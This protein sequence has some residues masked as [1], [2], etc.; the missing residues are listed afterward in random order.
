M[1]VSM[2]SLSMSMASPSWSG[3]FVT[4]EL[5]AWAKEA[6]QQE[7]SLKTRSSEKRTLA[8]CYFHNKT[9]WE[10]LTLLQKG[11]A[12]M[13]L[14]DLASVKEIQLV[15]RGRM[16]ALVEELGLGV[17]GLVPADEAPRVGRLL[18]AQLLVGGD[19][20]KKGADTFELSSGL[21]SVPIVTMLGEPVVP[22]K[23]LEE[24]F[25]MEKDLLFE[26]IRLLKIELTPALE[27]ELKKTLTDSLEALLF[28]F[29]AIEA[30]DKGQLEEGKCLLD[31]SLS[32]DPDL[33][34]ADD[35]RR[36]LARI[37]PSGESVSSG[38]SSEGS[39]GVDKECAAARNKLK[40][41]VFRSRRRF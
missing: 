35:V 34:L 29:Q 16:Q 38:S 10:K 17:A 25:R 18:G 32:E 9:G 1:L 27:A 40:R 20:I 2:V 37:F 7:Q 26:I 30:I 21:L 39:S 24:L 11:L 4:Q 31:K 28:L 8:V 6:V 15:E 19:I 22:G 14:T 5:R 36:E 23:L 41:N 3:Q 33:S 13:L 12:V